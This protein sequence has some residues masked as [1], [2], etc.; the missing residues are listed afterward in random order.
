MKKQ[1]NIKQFLDE[2][3][4]DINGFSSLNPNH[5]EVI[6]ILTKMFVGAATAIWS[7]IELKEH[8]KLSRK[9]KNYDGQF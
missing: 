9:Y 2:C 6:K 1:E 4:F 7:F 8:L 5:S 3:F